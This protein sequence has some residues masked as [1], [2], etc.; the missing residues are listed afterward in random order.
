M[1]PSLRSSGPPERSRRASG[2]VSGEASRSTVLTIM[3]MGTA[4]KRPDGAQHETPDQQ[5]QERDRRGQVH[6]DFRNLGLEDVVGD[7]VDHQV[8]NEHS[9]EHAPTSL[10]N[11]QG[12][13]R[14]QSDDE[15][16]VRYVAHHEGEE[17][18]M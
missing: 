1:T 8:S 6:P 2:S 3:V 17:T 16:Q 14:Q 9:D 13:G 15:P 5:R 4:K 10:E 11:G 7:E 12:Q 18:P